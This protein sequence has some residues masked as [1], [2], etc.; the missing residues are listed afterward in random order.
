MLQQRPVHE[1]GHG[2]RARVLGDHVDDRPA[3]AA[4]EEQDDQGAVHQTQPGHLGQP[5]PAGGVPESDL[6]RDSRT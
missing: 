2:V 1:C 3:L 4:G 5:R 6:R